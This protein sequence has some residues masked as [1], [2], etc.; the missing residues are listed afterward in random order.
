MRSLFTEKLW[1]KLFVLFVHL[2]LSCKNV[3]ENPNLSM[4]SRIFN[5]NTFGVQ[6]ACC[7]MLL[8][9]LW[10]RGQILSCVTIAVKSTQV[11]IIVPTLFVQEWR[12][13]SHCE[14]KT[15]Y[16]LLLMLVWKV[17]FFDIFYVLGLCFISLEIFSHMWGWL[18]PKQ[19]SF[20]PIMND[21]TTRSWSY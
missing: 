8:I 12:A 20:M 15:K 11:F 13:T 5:P 16:K 6:C 18:I 3:N 21:S 2:S 7:Q 17:S 10:I 19:T 1:T 9:G 4:Q 14:L